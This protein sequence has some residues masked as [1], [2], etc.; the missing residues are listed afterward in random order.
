MNRREFMGWVGIGCMATSLPVAIAA[1]ADNT[2]NDPGN[3]NDL[4]S[5]T[6]PG[7]GSEPD[8]TAPASGGFNKIATVT[9]LDEA[10]S[11][12]NLEGY[13][14]VIVVRDPDTNA[15]AAYDPTC[16]HQQCK[17][18]WQPGEKAMV[19]PC[20]DSKFAASDGAVLAGPATEPLQP[21]EFQESDGDILVNLS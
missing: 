15:I 10:G 5:A 3:G 12:L 16:P 21:L 4:T 2:S 17:V 11:V 14:P 19:C 13:V 1:C 6:S 18:S 7:S 8:A 9:E 20:H